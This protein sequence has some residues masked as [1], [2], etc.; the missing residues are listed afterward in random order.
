MFC[1]KAGSILRSRNARTRFTTSFGDVPI[2]NL[3]PTT[4]RCELGQLFSWR[5]NWNTGSTI[6][7][8]SSKSWSSLLPLNK[9]EIGSRDL[10]FPIPQVRR[11]NP[12]C[13]PE[14]RIA[15]QAHH[16]TRDWQR[17]CPFLRHVKGRV[18]TSRPNLVQDAFSIKHL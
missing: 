16:Q 3:D 7:R 4:P 14:D 6:F 10:L 13:H 12:L 9:N 2:C 1:R 18:T 8:K 17:P 11:L 15:D 5:L